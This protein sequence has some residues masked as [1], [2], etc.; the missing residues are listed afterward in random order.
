MRAQRVAAELRRVPTE[1]WMFAV[2]FWVYAWASAPG[3]GWMDSGELTAAAYTLGGAHPPGHPGH[4][5][6]GKLATFV[7]VGEIAFRVSVLSCASMA[8]ALS[9]VVALARRLSPDPLLGRVSGVVAAALAGLAPAAMINAT[10]AEVYAP[11]AAL[12]FWSL[13]ATLE[14]GRRLKKGDQPTAHLVLLAALGCALAATF[15]PVIAA[16]TALPMAVWLAAQIGTSRCLRLA[17]WALALAALALVAYVYMPMRAAASTPPLLVWGEPTSW[18]SFVRLVSGAAYQSNFSIDGLV[19]R[20]A[21]AWSLVGEFSALGAMVGGLIGLGLGAVTGLRPARVVLGVAVCVVL[22]AALQDFFNP[23][24]RG[25]VLVAILAVAAGLSPLLVAAIRLLPSDLFE[26]NRWAKPVAIAAILLPLSAGGVL[27]GGS[28]ELD[29]GDDPA[30]L[31]RETVEAMPPGPGLYF[32]SG[33]H[34]LFAGQY[35]RL[36]AGGRPD[37][38]LAHPDLCR[39]EWFLRHLKR[40]VPD[41]YVPYVDDGVRGSLAE[42]LAVSNLRKGRTVG[43]D[44]PAFGRLESKRARPLARGFVWSLDIANTGATEPAP[45]PPAL[46]G[47][48]G[49]RIAQTLGLARADYEAERGRFAEAAR[50]AGVASQVDMAALA[51]AVPSVARPPLLGIMPRQ[52]TMLL[53]EPWVT[54]LFRDDLE[55][56]A[57]LDAR[58]PPADAPFERQ[59]HARWRALLTEQLEPGAPPLVDSRDVAVATT[60][61]LV[62]MGRASAVEQHLRAVV[63]AFPR[64]AGQL[65]LLA[66]L[67]FNRGDLPAAEVLFRRSLAIDAGSA[68]THARLAMVLAMQGKREEADAVWRDARAIDGNLPEHLPAPP[69]APTPAPPVE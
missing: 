5:L 3:V 34:T 59:V 48:M 69:P 56:Q 14:V 47:F 64:E 53:H 38:A 1:L 44:M 67:E 57:G 20:F 32:T 36:V 31:W 35:E 6:L 19:H 39:D 7:P 60:R 23:D 62:T 55:W 33:D 9:A 52:T 68:E 11:A 50:A 41:L 63:A 40:L 22:G 15:H 8:A 58:A 25:Y 65:A 12:L 10:R 66:S 16:A 27:A 46:H 4:S 17:P 30:W 51:A 13:V 54:Q 42:R 18:G 26:G 49:H 37:I 29:R 43:G 45:P 21:G 28:A 2:G 61:L 24:L